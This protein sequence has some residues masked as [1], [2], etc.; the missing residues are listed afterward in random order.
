MDLKNVFIGGKF[1]MQKLIGIG[2]F[3]EIYL[4]NKN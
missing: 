1:T 3:G 2:S 4:G